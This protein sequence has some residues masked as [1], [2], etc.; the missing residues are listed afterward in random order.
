VPCGPINNFSE[1]FQD[2]DLLKR[3]MI[4]DLLQDSGETVKVP[5]NPVKISNHDE[6]FVRAPKLG[7]HTDE[8]IK[9]WLNRLESD[10]E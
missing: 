10:Q 6:N 3:N 8:I 7:E 9:R 4:V 1:T 5:G 2:E